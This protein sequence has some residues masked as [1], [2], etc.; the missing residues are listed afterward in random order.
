[1]RINYSVL[2]VEDD[3]VDILSIQRAFK[4][5]ELTHALVVKKNGEEA[6]EYLK[7]PESDIPGLILLDLNMPKVGGI[8]FLKSIKRSERLRL[9]PAVVLT[10]STNHQ[11]IDLAYENMA[12][13]YVVKPL[14]FADFKEV[15]S[16]IFEY[17]SLCELPEFR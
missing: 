6:L 1:M 4:E 14:D 2:L 8:E 11:D 7:N 5:L 12:A 9:I 15:V 16:N 13:G 3:D 17:W 10:T